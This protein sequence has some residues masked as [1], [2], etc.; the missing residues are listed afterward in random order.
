M[1]DSQQHRQQ[2]QQQHNQQEYQPYQ[3]IGKAHPNNGSLQF[4]FRK[5]DA[6][7]SQF[8]INPN[9]ELVFRAVDGAVV[10]TPPD[11]DLEQIDLPP[12]EDDVLREINE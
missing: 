12:I 2:H 1:V 8:P 9:D 3:G 7:D 5:V 4:Y 11:S 6:N 10:L